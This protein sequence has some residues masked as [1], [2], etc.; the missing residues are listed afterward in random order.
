MTKADNA[1]V[2]FISQAL[3]QD[4][5]AMEE[6]ADGVWAIYFYDLLLAKL[7]ERNFKIYT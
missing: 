4:W 7:D 1:I 3:K 2:I 6:T 5:I